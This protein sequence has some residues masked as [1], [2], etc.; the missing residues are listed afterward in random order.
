VH[1]LLPL[2]TGVRPGHGVAEVVLLPCT[3]GTAAEAVLGELDLS[4]SPGRRRGNAG[5]G[6]SSRW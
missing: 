2:H 1:A 4:Y 5:T 3:R 6:A